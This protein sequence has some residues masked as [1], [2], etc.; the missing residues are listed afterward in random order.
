MSLFDPIDMNQSEDLTK[1]IKDMI[2]RASDIDLPDESICT[3]KS[4]LEWHVDI[5]VFLC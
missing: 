3:L 4:I 2:Q 5:F 1:E